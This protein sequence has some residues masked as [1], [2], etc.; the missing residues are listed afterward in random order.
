[1]A[2]IGQTF[3]EVVR[4]A[5]ES[6]DPCALAKIVKQ[7]WTAQ[8]VA[9]LI[10]HGDVDVRRVAAAALG[11]VGDMS[12][13]GTLSR[14]LRDEDEQVNQMAEH[15]MWS[16]WFRGSSCKAAKPF[17]E[18]VAL[19]GSESYESA[20]RKFQESSQIDPQF[21]EAYNQCA[22]AHFFMSEWDQAIEQC[23]RTIS[24]NPVHFGAISGLGH[25]FLQ[26]KHLSKA[27]KCY[28]HALKINPRMPVIARAVERLA[29][30]R[31]DQNDESGM[32]EFRETPV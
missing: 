26:T 8:E 28:R 20:V 23:K 1:M 10:D 29:T 31:S 3:L 19:L 6:C 5:L 2:I 30:H 24:L 13:C 16:I 14:A 17:R 27:L 7:H 18:G 11:F 25:C 21:A 9:T 15:S 4:P 12:C 32:F 22:I